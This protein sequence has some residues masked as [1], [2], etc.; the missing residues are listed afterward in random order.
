MPGA[1]AHRPRRPR[2][3]PWP[4]SLWALGCGVPV[5]PQRCPAWAP[6][7][8]VSRGPGTRAPWLT[9]WELPAH[10]AGGWEDPGQGPG[11]LGVWRDLATWFVAGSLLSAPPSG[12]SNSSLGSRL[13]GH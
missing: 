2:R 4:G 12:K 5:L 8:A 6:Y 13:Q 11:R 10:S 7:P 3:R 1:P 9:R